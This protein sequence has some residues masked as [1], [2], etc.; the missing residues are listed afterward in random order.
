[1]AR[2]RRP[3]PTI[4]LV[5]VH[6]TYNEDDDSWIPSTIRIGS[7]VMLQRRKQ[8]RAE[9]NEYR[10]HFKGRVQAFKV[11]QKSLLVTEV[12]IQHV[13]HHKEL[14]VKDNQSVLPPNRPNCE[15]VCM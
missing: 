1:M 15:Y 4:S 7:W 2:T 11:D 9:K 14:R 6:N 10:E 12:L 5:T 3:R 13:Y 8:K